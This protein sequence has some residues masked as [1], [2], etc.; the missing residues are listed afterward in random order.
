VA[1]HHRWTGSPLAAAVLR[2]WPFYARYRFDKA[3]SIVPRHRR[4]RLR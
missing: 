2:Y 4:G 1:A 3:V